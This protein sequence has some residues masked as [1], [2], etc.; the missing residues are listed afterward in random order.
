MVNA[1]RGRKALATSLIM[2]AALFVGCSPEAEPISIFAAAGA[3]P[4]LVMGQINA[5]IIW[6]F[7]QPLAPDEIETI[8]LSPEQLTGIGEMQIAISMYSKDA[9][10]AQQFVSFVT[11]AEGK[12]I[13]EKHGYI[14]EREEVNKYWR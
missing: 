14:V 13:F 9:K 11:S 8:E 4:A 3:K 2:L 6:H 1:R 12:A 5:G 10:S 7:Y